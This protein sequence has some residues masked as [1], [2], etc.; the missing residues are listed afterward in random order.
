MPLTKFACLTFRHLGLIAAFALPTL[1]NAAT[2]PLPL[3]E[4]KAAFANPPDSARPGVYWYFMDG[5]LSR[6]GMTRDLESMKQA[7]IA[8]VVF[9]EV[10]VGVPRGKV[11]FLSD[12]WLELFKHANTE[13]ERLGIAITLGTGPGWAGSGGPW[14]KAEQ[15]MRHLVASEVQVSGGDTV[16]TTLPVPP[17]K[18]PFFGEGVFTPELRKK[19]EAYYEDVA[20]LAFPTPAGNLRTEDADEKALYYRP[21]YTSQPNVKPYFPAPAEYMEVSPASAIPT[22]QIIDLTDKLQPDGSITWEAPDGNWTIMR[23]GTRNNGMVTRPAPM[24]GLGF[25]CDKFSKEH[26]QAHLDAFIGKIFDKIGPVDTN[27][28]GGLAAIHIDSWEMGAQNWT[29]DFREQFRQRRGYDPLPYYPAYTGRIVENRKVT[30]RFLWDL[31]MTAQ[32]LVLENH[33]GAVKEFSHKHDLKLS[34]EPYDMNPNTDLDLGA[35]ADIPMCEFWSKGFGF[36]SAFSCLEA[37]SIANVEGISLVQAEA[38][39]ADPGEGWL[40]YPGSMKNQGDWAFA[41]GINRFF[42]HT[43]AHQPL[44]EE[45]VPGMTMGPY[46]VHWDRKQTWWPMASEYHRYIA[47]CQAVLQQGLAVADIL[48]LTSEGAPHVFVPPP[49]ATSGDPVLPDKRGYNFY[50]CSPDQLMKATVK[51]GRITFPGGASYRVLVL[52]IV[53][54]M[55]VGLRE[56]IAALAN[57]GAIIVGSPAQESPSLADHLSTTSIDTKID[58]DRLRTSNPLSKRDGD[59]LYPAYAATAAVLQSLDQEEDFIADDAIRYHHRVAGDTHIYFLSNKTTATVN[60]ECG[61]RTAGTTPE[62]WDPL[63]GS[64]QSVEFHSDNSRTTIPLQFGPHESFFII[65][66]PDNIPSAAAAK[67]SDRTTLAAL[68]GS[69]TVAFDPKLG[70]PAKVEFDQLTDWTQRPEDDIKYYS[71][72]ATYTKTFDLPTAATS[73]SGPLYLNLGTVKNLARV[74]LNGKELGVLWT[75]PWEVEISAAAKPT[76][77]VLEVE[78]ANLWPNRLIGDLKQPDTGIKNNEWPQWL[79]EGKPQPGARVTFTTYNP[80]KAD[81]PLLPSGL[82]G[83]VEL[84]TQP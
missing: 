20:M 72:I 60:S 44:P 19:W 21:P 46:G 55:T 61:F 48:Y 76:G 16:T 63:K 39:T 53:E 41:L 65:F 42:Y 59:S 50:A 43:F 74:R 27:T 34:I 73:T 31:R 6:E 49:S 25:E 82:L 75:D 28:P 58:T 23:F 35:V 13:A 77:N 78:V 84:R 83:P 7:G 81:T 80:H 18:K 8:H 2:P 45:L 36:N 22:E 1:A 4:L 29:D 52:P 24:P 62:L 51:D 47:R 66:S 57:D 15:S 64:V 68:E 37:T 79:L 67:T 71:G 54:T 56:K 33:A 38:F 70:G 40:Q 9:L 30:E 17:P 32:E 5:N 26:L 14:V 11:D 69:W 12:E 3:S 10:S